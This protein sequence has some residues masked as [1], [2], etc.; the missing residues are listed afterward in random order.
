M[1]QHA[2]RHLVLGGS[3]GGCLRA[4]VANCGLMGRVHVF[5]DDLSHGPLNDK[6]ARAA[7]FE[8]LFQN[9]GQLHE[10]PVPSLVDFDSLSV[11]L[12][13]DLTPEVCLWAGENAS[14]LTFLEMACY[15]L[16]L[17]KGSVTRVGTTGLKS[18]P[19]IGPQTPALL[20]SLFDQREAVDPVTRTTL[21]SDF[22]RLRNSGATLR[23]WEAGKIFDVPADYYDSLLL[24]CFSKG[25]VSAASVVGTA[26]GR[27][28]EHNLLGDVFLSGRL[29]YLITKGLIEAS[30]PQASLRDYSVR[31]K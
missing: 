30:G 23:K 7:Y 1:S 29:Q 31:R 3:A 12:T 10:G 8:A 20:A 4:A 5:D 13:Q 22:L 11:Q 24:A 15:G 16:R 18:L 14:E 27:C 21:S 26:M 28:D 19:Y 25:W 2:Y 6:Q 9:Y 17:F